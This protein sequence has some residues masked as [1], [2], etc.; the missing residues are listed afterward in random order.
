MLQPQHSLV[1]PQDPD[2]AYVGE[3]AEQDDP[4][5]EVVLQLTVALTVAAA[6]L[7]PPLVPTPGNGC[8]K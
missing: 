6:Q 1:T 8:V 2:V 5:E 4:Q 7:A 3:G